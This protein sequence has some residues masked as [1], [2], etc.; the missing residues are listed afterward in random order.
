MKKNKGKK[1]D[2]KE[3]AIAPEMK[4]VTLNE[5]SRPALMLHSR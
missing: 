3:C 5:A 4:I 1:K 2:K